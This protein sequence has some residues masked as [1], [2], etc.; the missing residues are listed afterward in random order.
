MLKYIVIARHGRCDDSITNRQ[1]TEK[2]EAQ[3]K[4]LAEALNPFLLGLSPMRIYTSIALWTRQ[5]AEMLGMRYGVNPIEFPALFMADPSND[6]RNV[7][8]LITSPVQVGVNAVILV[9]HE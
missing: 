7:A 8:E 4:R 6:L 2:G 5:S 9:T 1:L 3:M